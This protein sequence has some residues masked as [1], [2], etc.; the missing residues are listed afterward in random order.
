MKVDSF[1]FDGEWRKVAVDEE[2]DH[3]LRYR[4]GTRIACLNLGEAII[5]KVEKRGHTTSLLVDFGRN[6]RKEIHAS[7]SKNDD[8][9]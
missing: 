3:T 1:M 7:Q 8:S 4:V 9:N 2:E 5:E 6:H